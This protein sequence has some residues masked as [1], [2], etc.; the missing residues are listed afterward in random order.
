M[1][2]DIP[3]L[4]S[5]ITVSDTFIFLTILLYGP[6]AAVLV[7]TL[8]AIS[9]STRITRKARTICF[10][11]SVLALATFLT[12]HI[13]AQ[14]FGD[15]PLENINLSADFVITICA[16]VFVQYLVNSGLAAIYE[17]LKRDQ[18]LWRTWRQHYLWTSITYVAGASGAAITAKLIYSVGFYAI[19]I[20]TP[21]IG[22]IFFTYKTYLQ[23]VRTAEANA[24][25]ARNHV[26]ELNH[27]ISEQERIREQFSQVEKMSA[28]GQLASGVAHDFN[29]C[30]AAMLGR[31]ELL[32]KHTDD[33]RM[34]RGLDL[35]IKS[36]HDG[37][38]TVKRIQDFARQ[39]R[40][41]DFKLLSVDS[42]LADIAEMTRPRWKDRA[43]ARNISILL[44]LKN[45]SRAWISGD[46]SELRDVLVNMVFNAAD[47]MPEG[48]RLTLAAEIEGEDVVISVSD[49]GIGMSPEVTSKVFD[50]FFTTK[51]V[52]GMGLGL[53]VSYGIIRRHDGNIEV[54]SQIGLGT[55]F[56]IKFRVAMRAASELSTD[57]I[58]GKE[59]EDLGSLMTKILVIDDEERVRGLLREILE[60]EG[61]EVVLASGG[62]EGLELFHNNHFDAV[63]TD[64]GMPEMSGW[65][66]VRA[67]RESSAELPVAVI[68]GWGEAVS[69]A[70]R[71][72]AHVDW[73]V[74]KPFTM[75]HI[76]MIVDEVTKRRELRTQQNFSFPPQLS[77][78]A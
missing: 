15:A 4:S 59:T 2:I 23:N 71:E 45:N 25:Q 48:G 44:D 43:E 27:Y 74:S 39:R 35:I 55:T 24:E 69:E 34:T 47:A 73:L 40:E 17:A 77:L 5:A 70:E 63:F 37:A 1:S 66:V 54:E 12:G 32:L 68:T 49:T 20:T 6:Q 13:W 75:A 61:H 65:E 3:R 7:A 38:R 19:I 51:G 50:P 9:S 26:K 30:L 8:E 33:P 67:I 76:S 78:S 62:H 21:I 72:N 28:L 58:L 52:E 10:N 53:A 60:D 11:A 42:M 16:M 31:A 18:R 57:C 29:N 36:A 22:I 56:R 46:V 41:H 64:V 14:K